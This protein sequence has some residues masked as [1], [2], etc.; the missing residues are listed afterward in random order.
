[1]IKL[2]TKTP[3]DLLHYEPPGI[4]GA[5]TR[6]LLCL[7]G[8]AVTGAA[9]Y[10][11]LRFAAHLPSQY[12]GYSFVFTTIPFIALGWA[13]PYGLPLEVF[14]GIYFQHFFTPAQRSAI[15]ERNDYLH[16]P[17]SPKEEQE[18]PASCI[19]LGKRELRRQRRAVR[20]ESRRCWQEIRKAARLQKRKD[21]KTKRKKA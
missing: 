17:V 19:P 20:A 8:T 2:E 3:I 4:L 13:K 6:Q 1:M 10:C 9:V 21:R 14:L 15:K 16:V 18:Y 11:L 7:G 12:L 5:S